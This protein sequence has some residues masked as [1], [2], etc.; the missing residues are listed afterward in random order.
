MIKKELVELVQKIREWEV[1][2]GESFYDYFAHD[3][4]NF[5]SWAFWLIGKGFT[6]HG[7]A[8]IT[9]YRK[10]ENTTHYVGQEELFDIYPEYVGKNKYGDPKFIE[11]NYLKNLTLLAEF[12]LA[13]P[14]YTERVM[15][16][17]EEQKS[18]A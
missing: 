11:K 12:L 10:E 13:T 8:I 14:V 4:V 18:N 6:E 7:N 1:D 15:K 3:N 17:F 5:V 9:E 16:F 2:A